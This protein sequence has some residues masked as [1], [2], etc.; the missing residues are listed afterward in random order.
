MFNE[1]KS[2]FLEGRVDVV[3]T[4]FALMIPVVTLTSMLGL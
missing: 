2:N 4:V 3:L 1:R